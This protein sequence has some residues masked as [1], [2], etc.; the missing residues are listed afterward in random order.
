MLSNFAVAKLAK[1]ITPENEIAR[2]DVCHSS[3]FSLRSK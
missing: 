2:E 1:L 3:Y